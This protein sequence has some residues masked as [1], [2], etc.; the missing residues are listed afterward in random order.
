MNDIP[1]NLLYDPNELEKG[2][3]QDEKQDKQQ[4]TS[5]RLV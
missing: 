4:V 2:N 1:A 3:K 5:E